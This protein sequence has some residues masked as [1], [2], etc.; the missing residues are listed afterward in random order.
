MNPKFIEWFEEQECYPFAQ[1]WKL[2]Q[3]LEGNY[4]GITT[5]KQIIYESRV[6]TVA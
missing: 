4:L 1:G 5:V 2:K 3:S 6:Y